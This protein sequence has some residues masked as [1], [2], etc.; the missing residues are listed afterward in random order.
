MHF[1]QKI[2]AGASPRTLDLLCPVCSDRRLRSPETDYLTR[3]AAAK[4]NIFVNKA[5]ET[6][7]FYGDLDKTGAR[8][9]GQ[10]N[11]TVTFAADGLPPVDGFWSL[12]VYNEHHFF[13][14]NELH[15]YSL[16]T[17]NK[18][19]VFG[20]D[21]SLTLYARKDAPADDVRANWLPAPDGDFTLYLRA[22]G[23]G[24]AIQDGT[25]TPPPIART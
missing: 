20:P 3:A 17:K 18:N 13:H 6:R 14:P 8:L 9:N 7:Y 5:I 25:W 1:L 2:F 10:A 4:S 21:G 15:R 19:L 22:Y 11:Y 24:P 16:G 12:T 23:P